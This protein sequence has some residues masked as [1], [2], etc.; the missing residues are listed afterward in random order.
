MRQPKHTLSR[1]RLA[2]LLLLN[3]T[4][5]ASPIRSF[6][7][8]Q[9]SRRQDLSKI[10][11]EPFTTSATA[12]LPSLHAK[13]AEELTE[14]IR[15]QL[16]E[17]SRLQIDKT[18]HSLKLVG[19][20]VSYR[21]AMLDVQGTLY[22]DDNLLVNSRV[23][24]PIK[25]EDDW[26]EGIDLVAEQLLDELIGDIRAVQQHSYSEYFTVSPGFNDCSSYNGYSPDAGCSDNYYSTWGWW[27]HNH[28]HDRQPV[29]S[30]QVPQQPQD[31]H[32]H[33]A[34]RRHKHETDRDHA[35]HE[36]PQH[37]EHHAL[38]D[39]ER[40]PGKRHWISDTGTDSHHG[41]TPVMGDR[42]HTVAPQSEKLDASRLKQ[43]ASG[44]SSDANPAPSA[45]NTGNNQPRLPSDTSPHHAR[46]HSHEA[47]PGSAA[48]LPQTLNP[49]SP[50][51]AAP[52]LSPNPV[53]PQSDIP[54]HHG[55]PSPE[56]RLPASEP[57]SATGSVTGLEPATTPPQEPANKP[58]R[59]IEP[60]PESSAGRLPSSIGKEMKSPADLPSPRE[61]GPR[62]GLG[63][64]PASEPK[65]APGSPSLENATKPG[66]APN[67]SQAPMPVSGSPSSSGI[68]SP[69]P[70]LSPS[71][72]STPKPEAT[73][74]PTSTAPNPASPVSPPASPSSP[75]ALSTPSHDSAP[76]SGISPAPASGSQSSG[77]SSSS[78]GSATSSAPVSTPSYNA[79][80]SPSIPPAPASGSQSSGGS[81]ASFGGAT[82]SAPVS[83]PSYNAAPSPSIPPA[84][85]YRPQSSGGS[86]SSFGG[87]TSASPASMPTPS[88]PSS[89]PPSAATTSV[90]PSPNVAPSPPAQKPAAKPSATSSGATTP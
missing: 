57:S 26:E 27:R 62:A 35:Q 6:A 36:H 63:S 16:A 69:S 59:V 82:S 58:G 64:A 33:D 19:S 55:K 1:F 12:G 14:A 75:G 89:A 67:Q 86:S 90:S 21:D 25:P 88:I 38:G 20:I 65:A 31:R 46:P 60:K 43:P 34:H 2:V 87:A 23:K 11:V 18:A 13:A 72:A 84:P 5:L 22:D 4:L 76:S 48:P 79:A 8:G 50:D 81:S 51:K 49:N 41:T 52:G 61:H 66:N 73:S 85:A 74:A 44:I 7:A 37:D 40:H 77:G 28:H 83:T 47:S 29:Q 39:H 10:I 78:F 54:R 15:K 3:L 45:T 53:Q 17:E 30:G 32:P 80:P 42:P 70:T 24:R 71:P 68:V 9:D 56:S